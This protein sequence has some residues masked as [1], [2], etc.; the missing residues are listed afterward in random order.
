MKNEELKNAAALRVEFGFL[1]SAILPSAFS[2][3]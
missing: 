3:Q 1:H 2:R